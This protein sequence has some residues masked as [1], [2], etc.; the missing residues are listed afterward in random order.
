MATTRINVE[1]QGNENGGGLLKRFTRKV[2]GS[3]IL[4]AARS[5]RFHS[6]PKSAYQ[7]KQSALRRVIRFKSKIKAIKMGKVFETKRGVKK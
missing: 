2:S 3:G 1:K 5:R 6:R 4:R 7:K